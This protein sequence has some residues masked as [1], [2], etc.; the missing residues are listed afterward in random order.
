[1]P[2]VHP[3][4]LLARVAAVRPD[5]LVEPHSYLRRHTGGRLGIR[6]V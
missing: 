6:L 2:A 3:E 1:V 5:H 4:A